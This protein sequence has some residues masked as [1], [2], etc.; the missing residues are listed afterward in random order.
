[1][2]HVFRTF[3]L[4]E[5]L[6]YGIVYPR[7]SPD[8]GYGLGD[9]ILNFYPP[10]AG[11]L[12]EMWHL[13]GLSYEAAFKLVL[14]MVIVLAILGVYAMGAEFFRDSRPFRWAGLLT[15]VAYVF[16]PYFMINLYW[17]G[18][19]AE[20]LAAAL[21][22]WLLWSLRRTF[23]QPSTMGYAI[24]AVILALVML[25]HSLTLILMIPFAGLYSLIEWLGLPHAQKIRVATGLGI[26][27]LVGAALSTFYWLPFMTE[28]TWVKMGQ[29]LE[30]IQW[31]F[32]T[33]FIPL[34]NLIQSDWVYQ[35]IKPPFAAGLTST[36]IS[37]IG[38][39]WV[40]VGGRHLPARKNAILFGALA[41]VCLASTV[42]FMRPL[43]YVLPSATLVQFPWRI[44][45]LVGL[46]LSLVVGALP[47]V[48]LNTFEAL[49]PKRF[50]QL[51]NRLL[52]FSVGVIAFLLIVAVTVNFV[53]PTGFY[54]AN[55]NESCPAGALRN[56]APASRYHHVGRVFASGAH[57]AEY[58]QIPRGK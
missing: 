27:A 17:R 46:G 10:I 13:F 32:Q 33:N 12:T 38:M 48:G 25:T 43:W 39:I 37:I 2:L 1:M 11:Y 41:F 18:A 21:L 30:D 36:M 22:P 6:R 3:H 54:S 26:A 29:G 14:W 5:T 44:S 51:T 7:W 31:V 50:N 49:L 19:H 15:T 20:A 53:R 9:A 35:Y 52:L 34:N 55:R 23:T 40:L 47:L 58:Y 8:L 4:D 28:L 42:E 45:L 57:R 56:S 16:F 24:V